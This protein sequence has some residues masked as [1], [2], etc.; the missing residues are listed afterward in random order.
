MSISLT[1]SLAPVDTGGTMNLKK[2]KQIIQSFYDAANNGDMESCFGLLADNVTWI[3]IGSTKFSGTYAGKDNLIENLL[4][5]VFGGLKAGIFS[6]I[7]NLIAEDDYVVV[8]FRG[9]AET[10]DGRPYN[11]TY[12]H[13]FRIENEMIVEVTEYFDTELTSSVFGA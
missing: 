6:T 13:V 11:N 12:C 1:V 5:P 3:N 7:D 9:T 8:Q 4:G 2:N 10:K